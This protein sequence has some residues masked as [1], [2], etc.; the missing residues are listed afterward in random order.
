M[1]K[2]TRCNHFSSFFYYLSFKYNSAC[3]GHP[4][5]HH[6]ELNNSSSSLWFTIGAWW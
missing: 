2:P 6:Q 1:N 4:Q 3:F 5:A